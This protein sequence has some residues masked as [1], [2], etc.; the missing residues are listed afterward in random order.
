MNKKS[1]LYSAIHKYV[2]IRGRDQAAKFLRVLRS[3]PGWSRASTNSVIVTLY[4]REWI[5]Q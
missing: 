4:F 5:H 1:I 3:L 2:E